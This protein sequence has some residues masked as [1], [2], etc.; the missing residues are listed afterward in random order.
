MEQEESGTRLTSS[1]NIGNTDTRVRRRN[2]LQRHR[3]GW[4][5]PGPNNL[6]GVLRRGAAAV[7]DVVEHS[8]MFGKEKLVQNLISACERGVVL[9]SSFAGSGCFESS[10]QQLFDE[11]ASTFGLEG[12]HGGCEVWGSWDFAEIAQAALLSPAD[13]DKSLHVFSDILD[14]LFPCERVELERLQAKYLQLQED[15]K[16]ELSCGSFAMTDFQQ[17]IRLLS[18]EYSAKVMMVLENA[19]FQEDQWCLRHQKR[20]PVCPRSCGSNKDRMWIEAGGSVCLPWVSMGDMNSWLHPSTL[21][22]FVWCYSVRFFEPDLILHECVKGFPEQMLVDIFAPAP[23]AAMQLESPMAHPLSMSMPSGYKVTTR[24]SHPWT[25]ESRRVGLEHIHACSC[26]PRLYHVLAKP[27][28]GD[29]FFKELAADAS[30]YLVAPESEKLAESK[31]VIQKVDAASKPRRVVHLESGEPSAEKLLHPGDYARLEG[32]R[33]LAM[34][35]PTL[36]TK[37]ADGE[38]DWKKRIA[39]VNVVQTETY[40]KDIGTTVV[41]CLMRRSQLVEMRTSEIVWAAEHWVIMGFP[42]P[43]FKDDDNLRKFFPCPRCLMWM[44]MATR[45]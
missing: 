8:K 12:K 11:M 29:I 16:A 6:H 28:F 5:P 26:S 41:P 37:L 39:L 35:D 27:I 42:H 19:E 31:E 2:T 20:C 22:F 43:G 30:I 13:H 3:S 40:M 15:S 36:C 18:D 14:R 44:R 34:Q 4:H 23:A 17:H 21:A 9:T 45:G 1:S 32:Y 7:G 25:L 10:S 33:C 38:I 24:V